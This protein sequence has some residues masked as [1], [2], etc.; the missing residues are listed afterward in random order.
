MGWLGDIALNAAAS[1]ILGVAVWGLGYVAVVRN[2]PD[3]AVAPLIRRRPSPDAL[4]VPDD[5]R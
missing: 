2:F 4:R 1:V 5:P 3:Q